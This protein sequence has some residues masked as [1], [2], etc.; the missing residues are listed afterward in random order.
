VAVTVTRAPAP[1]HV[2]TDHPVD[3]TVAVVTWNSAD[4]IVG[5]LE[6]LGGVRA[7]STEIHVVDNASSDDTVELVRR[8]FPAVRVIRNDENLGFAAACNE[9]WEHARGRYWMLLNPDAEVGPGALDDLVAFMDRHPAAGLATPTIVDVDGRPQT[10][11]DLVPSVTRA[12]V[13]AF[14][15][16]KLLPATFRGRMAFGS[17]RTAAAPLRVGWACGAA[18]IARADAVEECGPLSERFFMYGED[19]EWCLRIG[20]AGW[21]IW[22][23]P[24]AIV[25]HRGSTSSAR[26]WDL[27]ARQRMI[28]DGIYTAV[29]MHRGPRYVRALVAAQLVALGIE[30]VAA[31]L[32]HRAAPSR[33]VIGY[34]VAALRAPGRAS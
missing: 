3:L 26:R 9:S 13:E 30:S 1:A 33:A 5:C 12:L 2:V 8:R 31:R 17:D 14:R 18:L 7:I 28:L 10:S 19:L 25:M 21:Q 32:R 11:A 16:D 24:D 6:S 20:R 23:C 34:H 29:E 27:D 4:L 15:V 22:C